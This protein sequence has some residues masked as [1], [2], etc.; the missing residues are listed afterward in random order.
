MAKTK[1]SST[2]SNP[3]KIEEFLRRRIS[4]NFQLNGG[5]AVLGKMLKQHVA[6]TGKT[7]RAVGKS[8]G[9]TSSAFYRLM[10]GK[11][12]GISLLTIRRLSKL[13]GMMPVQLADKILRR[14]EET[15]L[16]PARIEQQQLLIPETMTAEEA[17]QLLSEA[18][19]QLAVAP[20]VTVTINGTQMTFEQ[21]TKKADPLVVEQPG[22]RFV[23]QPTP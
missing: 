17:A 13:L 7:G 18:R 9:V 12:T 22:W 11:A 2:Y 3:D 20:A 14:G 15:S 5:T 10:N 8:I 4:G 19:L 23:V 1:L 16:L 21:L 6:Q